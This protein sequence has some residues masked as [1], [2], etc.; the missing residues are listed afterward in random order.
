MDF[1]AMQERVQNLLARA[2]KAQASKSE[3]IG[4]LSAKR[5]ELASLVKE[6]KDAGYNPNTVKE[7]LDKTEKELKAIADKFEVEI[8]KAEATLKEFHK[9]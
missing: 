2:K 3:I 5:E 7:D 9:K 4:T 6:I 1:E 8:E